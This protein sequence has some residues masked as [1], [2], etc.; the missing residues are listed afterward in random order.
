MV[1]HPNSKFLRPQMDDTKKY[2]VQQHSSYGRWMP[3]AS[4]QR[5]APPAESSSQYLPRARRTKCSLPSGPWISGRGLPMVPLV[6]ISLFWGCGCP[7]FIM[8][9]V[10]KVDINHPMPPSYH[11]Y[12]MV[13]NTKCFKSHIYM[14]SGGC[15][16]NGG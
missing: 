5:R 4:H 14:V 1:Y 13:P 3:L 15:S 6:V 12:S 9:I 2:T 8:F 10:R 11:V 7:L 16:M